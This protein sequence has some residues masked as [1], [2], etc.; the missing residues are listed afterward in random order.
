VELVLIFWA[1]IYWYI[2]GNE[3]TAN[4]AKHYGWC[5]GIM[6][7]YIIHTYIHTYLRTY[8]HAHAY[9]KCIRRIILKPIFKKQEECE[10]NSTDAGL[11]WMWHWTFGLCQMQTISQLASEGLCYVTLYNRHGTYLVSGELL[12]W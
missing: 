6:L 7:P 4:Y 11:L 12:T 1:H 5:Q 10:L 2:L 3:W 9:N 8:I